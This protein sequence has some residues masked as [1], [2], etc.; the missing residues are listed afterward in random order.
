[1]LRR[2]GDRADPVVP[3]RGVLAIR[4]GSR[5]CSLQGM[6]ESWEGRARTCDM[7]VN[8]ALLCRLSYY[9]MKLGQ[10]TQVNRM[11]R[12]AAGVT[13]VHPCWIVIRKG[14]DPLTNS[15]RDR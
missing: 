5:A 11:P 13:Q 3:Q 10:S 6:F 4:P 14:N 7:R 8:S 9:P 2:D 12:R 15:L 1:M